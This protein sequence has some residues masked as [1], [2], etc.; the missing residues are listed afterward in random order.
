MNLMLQT[1]ETLDDRYRIEGPYAKGGMAVVYRGTDTKLDRTVAVKVMDAGTSGSD[2]LR[3]RFMREMRTL[4][5]LDHPHIVR[6]YDYGERPTGQPFIVMPLV[7]GTSLHDRLEQ[8]GPFELDSTSRILE[9]ISHA[10]DYANAAGIIH[11]DVKPLNVLMEPEPSD[12]AYLADFGIAS[13]SGGTRL[14]RSRQPQTDAYASPEQARG[15]MS[16]TA[17]SD[18]FSLACV[19]FEMLTGQRLF[20]GGI[21][22]V[23]RARANGLVPNPRT[24][25]PEL[26]DSAF[27]VL[28]KALSPEPHLRYENSTGF[29]RDLTDALQA[30]AGRHAS[31]AGNAGSSSPAAQ[32]RIMPSTVGAPPIPRPATGVQVAQL[33][34]DGLD[35]LM[36]GRN[37]RALSHLIEKPRANRVV[38]SVA[39]GIS[40]GEYFYV[41]RDGDAW[42]LKW[43]PL[44][45]IL[46]RDFWWG[47]IDPEERDMEGL[48]DV[49]EPRPALRSPDGVLRTLDSAA[50]RYWDLDDAGARP[51][52]TR[53]W[54][55]GW[56]FSG[57][58]QVGCPNCSR[59]L[60]EFDKD[61]GYDR[62]RRRTRWRAY[63]CP[64]CVEVF[65]ANELGPGARFPH[66]YKILME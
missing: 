35:I 61:R 36:S 53:F 48:L 16:L 8:R 4:A 29:V 20:T 57:H 40:P 60:A 5:R 66:D 56:R 1:G 28:R 13:I 7:K 47:V 26:P 30:S 32:T 38:R 10:L 62:I 54:D 50:K 19:A 51:Q 44:S 63:F 45:R 46:A 59:A 25:R 31:A 65:G 6:I 3:R 43:Q 22:D 55:D 52:F 21:E 2:T 33:S 18:Q 34:M 24:I 58:R 15:E 17:Q 11:R 14:T 39:S 42:T 41:D 9:A 64:S 49:Q 27:D 23:V 37:P 12:F